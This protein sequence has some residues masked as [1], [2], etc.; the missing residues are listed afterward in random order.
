MNE[1]SPNRSET[2]RD[3]TFIWLHPQQEKG[4]QK[5]VGLEYNPKFTK[6][7]SGISKMAA[8]AIA[9]NTPVICEGCGKNYILK[10]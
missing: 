6:K 9:E 10:K 1:V 5:C 8:R 2:E 4:R 7:V 3:Y